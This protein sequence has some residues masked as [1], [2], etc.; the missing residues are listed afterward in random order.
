MSTEGTQR[1]EWPRPAR[2]C[3]RGLLLAALGAAALAPAPATRAAD[4]DDYA[5][6]RTALVSE[7]ERE[8]RE[9]R[10]WLGKDQL[11]ARV[12]AA[13]GAVPR[14]EFVPEALRGLA[15][16]N[17][18]L[19]IGHEQTISQPYIVAI[20]TDLLATPADG[21]VLEI[22]TGS[23]YQAAV[24][25]E[26]VAR[27]YTIEIVEPLGLEARERLARLGYENV[28][29]RIGDGF[30]GWPEQAPFDAIIV[31]AAAP[32]V[33]PPLLEQLAPGGRM[34]IPI[35][36]PLA[37][38]DLLLI[39]KDALGHVSRREVLPVLFVPLTRDPAAGTAD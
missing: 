34:L 25:A 4:P 39:E 26:L 13:L 3:Q 21:R 15:Y 35:G 37:G 20:M 36:R 1:L 38:Q 18:P 6:A 14:H 24:L 32:E 30:Q 16:A 22:G 2:A 33:P 31:T 28:E 29:V 9:T 8:V 7:I 23:G 5:A 19:P 11:D 27:V 12:I 17:R 10:A